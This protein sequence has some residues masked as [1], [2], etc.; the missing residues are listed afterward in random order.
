MLRPSQDE[1]MGREVTAAHTGVPAARE[2]R[3]G[4]SGWITYFS[5]SASF[6]T[7]AVFIRMSE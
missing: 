5:M 3:R 2:P 4:E 1:L 6:S 7:A